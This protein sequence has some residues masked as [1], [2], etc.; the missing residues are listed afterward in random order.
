MKSWS[1]TLLGENGIS[2]GFIEGVHEAI[3][4]TSSSVT[5]NPSHLRSA[6]SRR[7]LIVNG[8]SSRLHIPS[9]S[10]ALRS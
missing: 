7:H 8:S 6:A 3:F 9:F 5:R 10:K 2:H 1:I 4:L